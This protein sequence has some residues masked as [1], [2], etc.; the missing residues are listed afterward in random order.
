M[1]G[2][3]GWGQIEAPGSQCLGEQGCRT[4]LRSTG[5]GVMAPGL[6]AADI[7]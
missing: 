6:L 3:G 2:G 4:D 5:A 7:P 1:A